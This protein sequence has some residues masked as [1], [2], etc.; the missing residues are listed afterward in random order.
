MGRKLNGGEYFPVYSIDIYFVL[1]I[2]EL[3]ILELHLKVRISF[4]GH[5]Y[6]HFVT[7]T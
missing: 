3:D 2:I 1:V 5:Q 6:I 7:L 4:S